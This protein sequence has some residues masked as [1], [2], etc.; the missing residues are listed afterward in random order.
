MD[1]YCWKTMG[2]EGLGRKNFKIRTH[3]IK[4]RDE[5]D[6]VGNRID[7]SVLIIDSY[8]KANAFVAIP[9]VAKNR[10]R[11]TFLT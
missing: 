4:S 7:I 1:C 11:Y 6:I 9:Y 3:G 10:R 5:N 2:P 8:Q